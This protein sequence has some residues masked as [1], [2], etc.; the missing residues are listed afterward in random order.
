[1][2]TPHWV[3]CHKYRNDLAEPMTQ[4]NKQELLLEQIIVLLKEIT[5]KLDTL[6]DPKDV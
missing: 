3:D 5:N 2:T 1:M 4:V 6:R